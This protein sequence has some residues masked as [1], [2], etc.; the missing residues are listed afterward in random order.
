MKKL[1]FIKGTL[2]VTTLLLSSQTF[3]IPIAFQDPGTAAWGGWD[4]GDAGTIYTHWAVIDQLPFD[5]SPDISNSGSAAAGLQTNNPGGFITGGGL[6]GN[7]YS[8]S[9]TPD[10]TAYTAPS[11]SLTGPVTVAMQIKVLG[12]DLDTD[13][14]TLGIGGLATAATSITT[15]FQGDAGG[16]F[17]GL[18]KE[19]LFTWDLASE[20]LG[21]YIFDFNAT[22]SSMSLDELAFDIG[23]GSI[24]PPAAVP[25]P[26]AIWLFGSA[27][28]GLVGTRRKKTV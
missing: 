13:S 15:L 10:F 8:F 7:I 17:G 28:F 11:V 20:E 26:A 27:L 22:G 4:R 23:P 18:D 3:A 12:T 9:D 6:G 19:Y 25:V 21:G 2:L 24:T 1:S 16:A 14:V 5:G